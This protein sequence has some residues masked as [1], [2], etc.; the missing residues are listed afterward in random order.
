[1]TFNKPTRGLDRRIPEE[2][3]TLQQH[4]DRTNQLNRPLT[5]NPIGHY[6]AGKRQQDAAASEA[7]DHITEQQLDRTDALT[8]IVKERK[9]AQ[10]RRIRRRLDI[11]GPNQETA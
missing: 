9:N 3:L 10:A 5:D 7:F 11:Y 8:K 6:T 2:A 1:M 4:R